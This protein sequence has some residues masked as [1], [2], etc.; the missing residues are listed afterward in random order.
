MYIV[1]FCSII[2]TIL[3][4]YSKYE[5]NDKL[6]KFGFAIVTFLGCIHY[7]YGND[8]MAYYSYFREYS[9]LDF[10]DVL[11]SDLREPGW[12]FINWLFKPFGFF[13]MVAA[14]N[15]LQ[16]II[17][18]TFIK[19]YVNPSW[20]WLAVFVYLFNQSFYLLNFSMMRQGLTISL[21]VWA[22]MLINNKRRIRSVLL[23]IL[24]Y[25]IH[26]SAIIG[27]PFLFLS[28]LPQKYIKYYG[29][30]LLILTGALFFIPSFA[31]HIFEF[32]MTTQSDL[33]KYSEYQKVEDS[34]IFGIGFVLSIIP[35][36]VSYNALIKKSDLL[37]ESIR[38]ITLVSI[39][40]LIVF[41]FQVVG[42]S[43]IIRLCSYFSVFQIVIIPELYGRINNGI[44][45]NGLLFI[46]IFVII[47][48]YNMFFH[49]PTWIESYSDFHTIIDVL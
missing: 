13:T 22:I 48:Q 41:P 27:L 37:N 42:A 12:G 26:T 40:G 2:A 43:M 4:Y 24:S 15:I 33:D 14:L 10:K 47:F 1:I 29:I 7:N 21:F 46:Y 3:A 23:V 17:Y 35:Y 8:Y 45:R 20:R 18:Y 6:L 49:S 36:F 39:F 16:N 31:S 9:L 38:F 30:S 34:S 28:F 44:V 25:T 19:L 5:G 11:S 32:A